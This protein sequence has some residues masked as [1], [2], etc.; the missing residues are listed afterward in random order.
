VFALIQA[1][2]M[3]GKSV[4]FVALKRHAPSYEEIGQDQTPKNASQIIDEWLLVEY[5][6]TWMPTNPEAL[7]EAVSKGNFELPETFLESFGIKAAMPDQPARGTKAVP[8]ILR[9]TALEEIGR[10]LEARLA[11][12]DLITLTRDILSHRRGAV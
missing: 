6:V 8:S 5:A 9:F 1:G 11:A 10:A 2:P 12:I 7:V 3:Q 4:G